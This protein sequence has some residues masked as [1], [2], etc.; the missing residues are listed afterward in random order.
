MEPTCIMHQ[1]KFEDW[2][3]LL[4]SPP[5]EDMGWMVAKDHVCPD[6]WKILIGWIRSYNMHGHP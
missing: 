6:C 2:G 4:I 5:A 1:G 3:G